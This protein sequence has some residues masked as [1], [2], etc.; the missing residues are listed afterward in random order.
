MASPLLSAG[1]ASGMDAPARPG[2]GRQAGSDPPAD[3]RS[4]PFPAQTKGLLT[5]LGRV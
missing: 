3:T 4:S 1:R 2:T 5:A